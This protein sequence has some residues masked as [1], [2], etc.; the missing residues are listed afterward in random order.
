MRIVVI[1]D[2]VLLAE[3]VARSLENDGVGTAVVL[4][5]AR[6]D[7]EEQLALAQAFE[8]RVVV[9]DLNFGDGRYGV[10]LIEPLQ[11]AGAAV[12][13]VSADPDSLVMAEAAR[14]GATALMDK[15]IPVDELNDAVRRAARGEK[16]L[17]DDERHRLVAAADEQRHTRAAQSARFARLS[18]TE[19]EILMALL[20]G[21][22]PKQVAA[23]RHVAVS[24]IRSQIQSVLA[25][26]EVNREREAVA[27]AHQ[28]G[29]P[30]A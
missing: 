1:E 18:P 15:A 6:H 14:A 24:T 19:R 2:H 29:W 30:R 22:A 27:L 3:A 8:A 4:D 25:K 17:S 13:V 28:V 11:A 16:V 12:I 9:L 5:A 26:L 21:R 20:D 23:D 10:P 7:D